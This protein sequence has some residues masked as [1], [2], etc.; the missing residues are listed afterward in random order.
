MKTYA[1]KT[2]RRP[3]ML[4]RK[5]FFSRRL[6]ASFFPGPTVQPKLTVGQ[7]G[8]KYEQEADTMADRVMRQ[9]KGRA[10]VTP[11]LENRLQR[12]LGSGNPLSAQANQQMSSDFGVDFSD[13]RIHT[14]QESVQLNRALGARAFTYGRDVF[15]NQSNYDPYSAADKQLLA[16]E[17]THVV[18]Q[19]GVGPKQI[20]N[21]G[22]AS[23]IQRQTS[24]PDLQMLSVTYPTARHGSVQHSAYINNT[25]YVDWTAWIDDDVLLFEFQYHGSDAAA[26][27]ISLLDTQRNGY[28]GGGL[29]RWGEGDS[30]TQYIE[31]SDFPR[32]PLGDVMD[33]VIT[34]T[35]LINETRESRGINAYKKI[36]RG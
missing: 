4:H 1:Q 19:G 26:V 17:L 9:E 8:D 34:R 27:R 28:I 2:P 12:S 22:L 30:D 20:Q 5:P 35:E 13:V 21:N 29:V 23:T 7:P 18:Q 14:G 3:A 11:A 24:T 6:S 31:F 10:G 16:H 32:R 25:Y 36:Y 15:F 33:S